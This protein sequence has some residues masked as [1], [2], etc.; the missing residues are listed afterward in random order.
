MRRRRFSLSRTITALNRCKA[1][2]VVGEVLGV[3]SC[4]A[5]GRS[6]AW[7]ARAVGQGNGGRGPFIM[8]YRAY[9]II[10]QRGSASSNSLTSARHGGKAWLGTTQSGISFGKCRMR[11]SRVTSRGR[12][13]SATWTLR[14]PTAGPARSNGALQRRRWS[15]VAVASRGSRLADRIVTP[16]AAPPVV[17]TRRPVRA[18]RPARP[19]PPPCP[20]RSR[21]RDPRVEWC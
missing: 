16:T 19:T 8:R 5:Y 1:G 12:G 10:V 6:R 11:S 7:P 20:P 9:S 17:R 13:C 21:T 15:F 14:P 4:Q 3:V 18:G 2:Q